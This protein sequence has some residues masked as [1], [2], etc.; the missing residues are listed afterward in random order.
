MLKLVEDS[1]RAVARSLYAFA[2]PPHSQATKKLELGPN[3]KLEVA[4]LKKDETDT[5]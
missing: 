3:Y 5:D 1:W 4:R 2:Y